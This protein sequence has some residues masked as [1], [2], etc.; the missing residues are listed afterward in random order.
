MKGE[1]KKVVMTGS[2]GS[3][4]IALIQQCIHCVTLMRKHWNVRG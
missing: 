3:I 1:M 4:G 2:T